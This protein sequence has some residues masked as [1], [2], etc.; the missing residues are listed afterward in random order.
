L[1]LLLLLLLLYRLT[2]QLVAAALQQL[3]LAACNIHPAGSH[4]QGSM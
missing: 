3:F 4:P 2:L 1:L